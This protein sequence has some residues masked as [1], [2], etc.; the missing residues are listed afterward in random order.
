[1]SDINTNINKQS[2]VI[3]DINSL[4]SS[5]NKVL[6]EDL[7]CMLQK[8][9]SHIITLQRKYV[10]GKYNYLANETYFKSYSDINDMFTQ[11]NPNKL[12]VEEDG[13]RVN[14]SFDTDCVISSGV[15]YYKPKDNSPGRQL[16][17]TVFRADVAK[18]LYELS[19]YYQNF[20][21][22]NDN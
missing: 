3:S 9:T 6:N 15:V 8:Y 10:Q 7:C 4:L 12:I 1:M 18:T 14:N 21:Q 22:T 13:F 17:V 16:L 5:S 2:D 11:L 19:D 20:G